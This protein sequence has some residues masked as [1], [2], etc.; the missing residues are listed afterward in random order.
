M[1]YAELKKQNRTL[2]LVI[3]ILSV[4]LG[5]ALYKLHIASVAQVQLYNSGFQACV[6]ENNIYERY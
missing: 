4:A 1:R 3:T 2:R 5:I 6:E